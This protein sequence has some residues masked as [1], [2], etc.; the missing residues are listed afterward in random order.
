MNKK[1]INKNI[2]TG[3]LLPIIAPAFI[4]GAVFLPQ[5]NAQ[6]NIKSLTATPSPIAEKNTETETKT[7][8]NA[9]TL[10]E[11]EN[12]ELI[13]WSKKLFEFDNIDPE[14]KVNLTINKIK[15]GKNVSGSKFKIYRLPIEVTDKDFKDKASKIT[16]REAKNIFNGIPFKDLQSWEQV[17]DNMGNASFQDLNPGI[18]I[19]QELTDDGKIKNEKLAILPSANVDKTGWKYDDTISWKSTES[20]IVTTEQ[21]DSDKDKSKDND[22][23]SKEKENNEKIRDNT[24][25]NNHSN[26]NSND[27]RKSEDRKAEKTKT[28]MPSE[29][30]KEER[31]AITGAN[32]AIILGILAL[33]SGVGAISFIA[34]R[35][36]K[37]DEEKENNDS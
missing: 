28:D 19:L 16:M 15:N 26:S 10:S 18:H 12:P 14:Y 27:T 6:E 7:N 36:Q 20:P 31:I 11:P 33:L 5:A 17:T 22:N 35:K 4:S 29:K 24:K 3:I 2:A 9:S 21:K 30:K 34:M 23:T 8:N 1:T 37:E 13:G 32:I 25:D